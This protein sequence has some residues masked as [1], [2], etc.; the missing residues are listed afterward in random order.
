MTKPESNPNGEFRAFKLRHS[1]VIRH[2][3]FVILLALF[4]LSN[5]FNLL[6]L[7]VSAQSDPDRTALAVEALSRLENIDLE[8]NA[9]VKEAVLKLLEKTRGTPDFLRLVEHFKIKG[10]ETALVDLAVEHRGDETG[11][12]AVRYVLSTGN[13]ALIEQRLQGRDAAPSAAAALAEALGNSGSK[14]AVKLLLPIVGDDKADVAVRKQAV[15]SLTKTEDGASAILQLAKDN[16]LADALRFTASTELNRVRWQYIRNNAA[17]VL[18]LPEG[19]NKQPLPP[20]VELLKRDGK[21]ENG[22]RV[23]F[24]QTAACATCH[25]VKGEGTEVGPDLSEIGSKLAKEALYESIL[26]P[27]AGISFG[28]EAW[29]FEL[30]NG[31]EPYGLIVSETPEEVAVKN[32]TGVVT[33]Y[34]K[35]EI[36]SRQQMKLSIMP[37]GLQQAMTTAELVDLVEYLASLKKRAN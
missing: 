31:D 21:I 4:N 35:S 27:S 25:K 24:T 28:Y 22:R 36:K 17:K 2:S 8:Q 5:P 16:K 9:K 3:S 11:A 29:Q 10:H 30:K 34:K 13:S 20:L 23:F 33:R 6:V 14:E 12:A 37:A 7:P 15:R 19:Q 1:F 18:P 26:D 32:N